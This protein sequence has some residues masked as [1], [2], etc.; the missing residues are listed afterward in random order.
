MPVSCS[1]CIV[2]A[3]SECN[4]LLYFQMVG[5][6]TQKAD[7]TSTTES[8]CS[9]LGRDAESWGY[10]YRGYLQHNGQTKEYTACFKQGSLVGVYL[11]TWKG[12]LQFFLD[13][14]PLG[15]LSRNV[16]NI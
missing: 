14:K 8:F 12:T 11:D 4:D 16:V 9:L 3:V 15:E 2:Q 1:D 10:S 6:G 13:R 7:L 5:V